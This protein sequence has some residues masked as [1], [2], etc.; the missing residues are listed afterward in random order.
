MKEM[1][2]KGEYVHHAQISTSMGVKICAPGLDEAVAGAELFVV[3]PDDDIEE[4]KDEVGDGFDSI[5]N[6]FEK[7][8]E[9]VYV[10]ASTLGSLEA[11]LSFLQDMKIPVFDVG[12]GEVHKKDVKKAGVMKEKKHPEFAVILAFDVKVNSEAKNLA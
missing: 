7:Q 3:G 2:V 12:I 4:L 11:L 6:N 10:K 5:L 1:R 8:A 9:G